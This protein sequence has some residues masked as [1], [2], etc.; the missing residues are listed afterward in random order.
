M[1]KRLAAIQKTF[2]LS[3]TTLVVISIATLTIALVLTSAVTYKQ[4]VSP[5]HIAQLV[6]NNPEIAAYIESQ[7]SASPHF[8]A[9]ATKV[10]QEQQRKLAQTALLV[11]IPVIL[12]SLIVGKSIA[13]K[14]IKPVEDSFE[15]Q[16]RFI[17]DAAHEL[18]NPLAAMSASLEAAH[19]K[20]QPNDADYQALIQK[21][22]RQTKQLIDINED[23]LFLQK[24]AESFKGKTNLDDLCHDVLDSF[25]E[26]IQDKKVHVVTKISSDIVVAIRPKDF[27]IILRN[28]L[29]NAV[30]YSPPNG[31][32]RIALTKKDAFAYL[33]I[34]DEG[35]GI[36]ENEVSL[37]TKRFYRASNTG[38]ISGSGLGLS[39]VQKVIDSYGGKFVM[40]SKQQKGTVALV[41][42]PLYTKN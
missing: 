15:T 9:L 10:K 38:S 32:V 42:L 31:T 41:L 3:I 12:I 26:K 27:E 40:K 19:I 2:T 36:P 34:S 39:L 29:D 30:K 20:K 14:L 5:N 13:K 18:R 23:L 33:H 8:V 16:E 21:L 37:V 22:N 28:L 4:Q 25:S 35:I 6:S 7:K 1:K 17:Q 24:K 11:S